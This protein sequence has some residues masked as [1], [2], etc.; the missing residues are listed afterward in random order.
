G[1][2]GTGGGDRRAPATSPRRVPSRLSPVLG[3]RAMST[4]VEIAS[5]KLAGAVEDG[6]HVFRGIPYARA[7][8]F[9][10]PEPAEPW[11]GV[12]EA[13][14]FGPA[15]H[16]NAATLGPILGIDVGPMREQ[17][18]SLNVWA[19]GLDG[20]RRG[21]RVGMQGGALVTGAS[22]QMIY[23]GVHIARRGDLVV[24]TINY[25]LGAPGFLRL[26]DLCGERIPASGNQGVLDQVAALE[27]VR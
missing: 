12:R 3:G 10:P 8:R 18:L 19:P 9:Q 21:V 6:I 2:G 4:T 13:T 5:G 23:D 27:W 14:S 15:S 24:V 17:C 26:V 20:G 22:S 1:R 16:Q 7:E 11:A 25:R